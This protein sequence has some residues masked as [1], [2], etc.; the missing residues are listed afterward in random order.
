[1]NNSWPVLLPSHPSGS[2]VV[3]AQVTFKCVPN[4]PLRRVAVV[5]GRAL[6]RDVLAGVFDGKEGRTVNYNDYLQVRA[7]S[8]QKAR[9]HSGPAFAVTHT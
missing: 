5:G 4:A 6:P 3:R 1:L 9:S 7:A 8:L 2:S